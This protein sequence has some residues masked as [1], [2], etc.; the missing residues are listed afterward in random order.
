MY[1]KI[2]CSIFAEP[3][4]DVGSKSRIFTIQN[5]LAYY[6]IGC[7]TKNWWYF[8]TWFLNWSSWSCR[9]QQQANNYNYKWTPRNSL[10]STTQQSQY[11]WMGS[12]CRFKLQ[13]SIFSE[14]SSRKSNSKAWKLHTECFFGKPKNHKKT[15][16]CFCW[17]SHD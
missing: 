16:S 2:Q 13:C 6:S 3:R 10:V 17:F 8:T 1:K 9:K 14:G 11:F 4:M 15:S 7:T 5:C 12:V